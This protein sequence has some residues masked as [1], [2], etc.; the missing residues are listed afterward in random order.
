V[1]ARDRQSLTALTPYTGPG[2]G[3]GWRTRNSDA[4]FGSG[5]SG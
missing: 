1:Y 3:L 4:R 2:G 5:L